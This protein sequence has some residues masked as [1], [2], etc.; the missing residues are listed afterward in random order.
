MLELFKQDPTVSI[1]GVADINPDAPG[2]HMA[3]SL[4]IRVTR[5]YRELLKIPGINLIID[6]TGDP[7]AREGIKQLKPDQAEVMGGAAARRCPPCPGA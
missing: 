2:L 3:T 7:E 6:V 5:D 4:G 1:L